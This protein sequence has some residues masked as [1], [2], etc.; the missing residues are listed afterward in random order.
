M[1][2]IELQGLIALVERETLL[3]EADNISREH[4][5]FAPA[6]SGE[7]LPSDAEKALREELH[8]RGLI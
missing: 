7:C 2:N 6:W 5:G 1:D 4:N 3:M 8:K